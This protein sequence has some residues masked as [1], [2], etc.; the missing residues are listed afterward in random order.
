MFRQVTIAKTV[1]RLPYHFPRFV[2][3]S[4]VRQVSVGFLNPAVVLLQNSAKHIIV[5]LVG[6]IIDNGLHSP[7]VYRKTLS[8]DAQDRRQEAS[9][10]SIVHLGPMVPDFTELPTDDVGQFLSMLKFEQRGR[11]AELEVDLVIS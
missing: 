2:S 1:L 3:G 4:K 10:S 11:L 7:F 8:P 6:E 9:G 5:T